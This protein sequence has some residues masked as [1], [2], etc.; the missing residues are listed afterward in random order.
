[1]AQEHEGKAYKLHRETKL[2]CYMSSGSAEIYLTIFKVVVIFE[3]IDL[4]VK[5]M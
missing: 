1:M 2:H 5:Y 4:L 3:I